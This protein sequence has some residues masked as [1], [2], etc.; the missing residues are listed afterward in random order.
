MQRFRHKASGRGRNTHDT[1]LPTHINN[2]SADARAKQSAAT[3][4][5]RGR[6]WPARVRG[7][8]I[9][10]IS[11]PHC[12]RARTGAGRVTSRGR[13]GETSQRGCDVSSRLM[14]SEL[15]EALV[16]VL[17]DNVIGRCRGPSYA[18]CAAGLRQWVD[19]AGLCMDRAG[20]TERER[21]AS[22]LPRPPPEL[23]NVG[24]R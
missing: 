14:P 15:L 11:S 17:I 6:G 23:G 5:A 16:A 8:I 18:F 9:H 21:G 1:D 22:G 10:P 4:G 20:R 13:R 3:S 19:D 24:Y 12:H 7:S 2:A